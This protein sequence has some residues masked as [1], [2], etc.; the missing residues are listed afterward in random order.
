MFELMDAKDVKQTETRLNYPDIRDWPHQRR[1]KME[2]DSLGFYVSGHPLD[3]Y[4]SEI[5]Q[6]AVSTAQLQEGNFQEQESLSLAGIVVSNTI[7][8]NRSSEK[9]AILV[10]EDLKGTLELAVYARAYSQTAELLEKDEPLLFS[11][12]FSKRDEGNTLMVDSIKLLAEV[13]KETALSM[14]L[15]LDPE[16]FSPD[17]MGFLRNLLQKYPGELP[18]QLIVNLNSEYQ[19][20]IEI[21]EKVSIVDALVEEPE[22][23]PE[24]LSASFNYLETPKVLLRHARSV[25]S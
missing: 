12:R 15:L 16:H 20:T 10:I 17:R 24:G 18:V 4:S 14:N 22:E 23:V 3:R 19:L 9:F 8:L 5:R 13:R 21:E 7:R 6:L 1:L 25:S 11:G 2:K